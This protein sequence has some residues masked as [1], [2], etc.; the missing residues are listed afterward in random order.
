[1]AEEFAVVARA[2]VEPPSA[3]DSADIAD[4][5]NGKRK[6]LTPKQRAK[7]VAH[8]K[9]TVPH[10]REEDYELKPKRAAMEIPKAQEAI[11]NMWKQCTVHGAK[12]IITLFSFGFG[13]LSPVKI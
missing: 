9:Y 6:E 2:P 13:G 8:L 1:M 11:S 7:Q 12:E 5:S 10:Q 4:G 3:G